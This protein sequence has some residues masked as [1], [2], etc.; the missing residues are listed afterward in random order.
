MTF[1]NTETLSAEKIM[2]HKGIVWGGDGTLG[3]RIHT[4]LMGGVYGIPQ[5]KPG[6]SLSP[7]LLS[8]NPPKKSECQ[9]P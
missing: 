5:V 9:T 3:N 1:L 6:Q 2:R 4:F 8:S 7:P